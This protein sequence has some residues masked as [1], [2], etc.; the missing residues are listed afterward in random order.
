M[1]PSRHPRPWPLT[2][3]RVLG[4]RPLPNRPVPRNRALLC[5]ASYQLIARSSLLQSPA[6]ATTRMLPVELLAH[7]VTA[8]SDSADRSAP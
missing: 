3:V 8:P 2:A 5:V 4:G 1:F 7:A 6:A